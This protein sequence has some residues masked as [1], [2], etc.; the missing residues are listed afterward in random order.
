MRILRNST[1]APLGNHIR[2]SLFVIQKRECEGRDE[3]N[4]RDGRNPLLTL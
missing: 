1:S 3:R 4:G 2:Y